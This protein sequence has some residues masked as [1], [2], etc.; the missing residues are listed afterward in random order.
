MIRKPNQTRIAD[1]TDPAGETIRSLRNWPDSE[2]FRLARNLA[3]ELSRRQLP[4]PVALPVAQVTC[5]MIGTADLF[6]SNHP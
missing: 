3:G 5:A 6:V 2:L 4:P 1:E